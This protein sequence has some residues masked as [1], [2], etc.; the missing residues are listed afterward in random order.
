MGLLIDGVWHDQ[1]YDTEAH[2]GAF[3][4]ESPGFRNWIRAGEDEPFTPEAG[5]YHLYVSLACP[6]AHRALILR[7]LKG[8]EESIGVRILLRERQEF[9]RLVKVAEEIAGRS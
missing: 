8:L 4:R 6:W 3:V 9:L 1:G 5:R 2:G 7:R